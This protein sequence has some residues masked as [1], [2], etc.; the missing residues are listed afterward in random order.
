MKQGNR[1][2]FNLFLMMDYHRF[3]FAWKYYFPQKG[4]F[5]HRF[6]IINPF[7]FNGSTF[8][9]IIFFPIPISYEKISIPFLSSSCFKT[10][11]LTYIIFNIFLKNNYKL[12]YRILVLDVKVSHN[13]SNRIRFL[14]KDLLLIISITRV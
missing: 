5:F 1:C 9:G 8:V 2:K 10:S 11:D 7:R 3:Y 13:F 4:F 6:I 14:L 12:K